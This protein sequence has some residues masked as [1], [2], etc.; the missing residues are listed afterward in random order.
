MTR[1]ELLKMVGAKPAPRPAKA[2]AVVTAAKP[3]APAAT[4]TRS[5]SVLNLDEWDRAAGER[6]ARFGP[7]SDPTAMADFHAAAFKPDPI[8]TEACVDARRE[9]FLATLM[10]TPEYAAL[11]ADTVLNVTASDAAA[12]EFA[13]SWAKLQAEDAKRDAAPK[14]RDPKAAA[15]E[16]RRG[17]AALIQA[18][19][20]ALA[21]AQDEVDEQHESTCAMGIGGIG[22]PD[23]TRMDPARAAALFERIKNS[24][25]LRKITELAGRFRLT[26]QAKQ[27][28][29]TTH[30]VDD[31]VGVELGGEI[32]RLV[33]TELA[34]LA[35]EDFELDA[36]R[37]LMERQSVVRQHR[38]VEKL[39]KGPIV[40]CVD[41]S[42]SM[43]GEP[44][45]RA[46]AFALA[47][48]WIARHQGRWCCLIG[49]SG[50]SGGNILTLPPSRWDEAKLLDWLEHFYGR[51][52]W[53]DMPIEELPR[54][55]WTRIK[56]PRGKTDVILIT[57]AQLHI[58]KAMGETFNAWKAAEKVR[59]VSLVIG[60]AAGDLAAVSDDVHLIR[61][62]DVREA[63][64]QS[65][66]SI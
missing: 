31:V 10:A 53:M 51:G 1:D 22:G 5:D 43:D 42:G 18:V 49:Y 4:L 3:D 64:V 14:P 2:D 8:K 60:D 26:A 66:L 19:G 28:T 46:K 41:E 24:P 32:A 34:M 33:P 7:I 15:R 47:M 61:E 12:R 56:P 38:G 59:C 29:K 39:G 23:A 58:P 25:T 55:Y 62:I 6:L 44:V 30:G 20:N 63:G 27:R 65:C 11:R 54:E 35:D 36:A 21:Q 16:D 52:S 9:R 37:R 45:Q 57:D 48:A 50:G 13:A 40:I 17:D